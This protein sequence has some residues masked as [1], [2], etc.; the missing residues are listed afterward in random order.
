MQDREAS[1]ASGGQDRF[2]ALL[3]EQARMAD[4]LAAVAP[5][6]LAEHHEREADVL[7]DGADSVRARSP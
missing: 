5:S 2:E 6:G 3:R 7:R 1:E 4:E